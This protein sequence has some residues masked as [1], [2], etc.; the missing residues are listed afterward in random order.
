MLD[1]HLTST[2]NLD[3]RVSR[4]TFCC[5]IRSLPF[6]ACGRWCGWAASRYRALLTLARRRTESDDDPYFALRLDLVAAYVALLRYDLGTVLRYCRPWLDAFPWP[7][8]FEHLAFM[9]IESLAQM[10][11]GHPLI[12]SALLDKTR[13]MIETSGRAWIR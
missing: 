8:T 13:Q 2:R 10:Y 12:A 5:A 7:G 9:M 1:D 11:G 3:R 6:A 4:L